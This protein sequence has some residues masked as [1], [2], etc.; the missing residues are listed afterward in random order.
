MKC[1][2]CGKE[3][4]FIQDIMSQN[5]EELVTIWKCYHCGYAFRDERVMETITT[6]GNK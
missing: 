5:W 4:K 2:K 6:G 1:K 3:M